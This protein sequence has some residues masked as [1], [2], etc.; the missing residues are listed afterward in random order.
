MLAL[1]L[2]KDW[3]RS[4]DGE[5]KASRSFQQDNTNSTT[6]RSATFKDSDNLRARIACSLVEEG[7]REILETIFSGEQQTDR[8]MLDDKRL[9]SKQLYEVNIQLILCIMTIV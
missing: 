8:A 1:S 5:R 2:C 3:I 4:K 6:T 7:V 9:R